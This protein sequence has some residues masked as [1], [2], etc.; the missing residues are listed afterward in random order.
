[1]QAAAASGRMMV[2]AAAMTPID[3]FQSLDSLFLSFLFFLAL[4]CPLH[5]LPGFAVR[6]APCHVWRARTYVRMYVHTPTCVDEAAP[7]CPAS[8]PTQA[9]F[10][11]LVF[12]SACVSTHHHACVSWPGTGPPRAFVASRP[13]WHGRAAQQHACPIAAA[14]LARVGGQRPSPTETRGMMGIANKGKGS[15]ASSPDQRKGHDARGTDRRR[16]VLQ[17]APAGRGR[18]VLCSTAPHGLP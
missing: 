13:D 10:F 15:S 8:R 14:C 1:M 17:Q 6:Q 9:F 4:P 16:P 12:F 3:A 18:A 11:F 5:A 7:E 2:A